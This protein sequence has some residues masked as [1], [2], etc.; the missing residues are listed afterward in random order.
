MLFPGAYIDFK[1]CDVGQDGKT[2]NKHGLFT[3]FNKN[4]LMRI[5][6]KW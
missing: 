3:P 2:V 4:Y 1:M 6:T 5:E